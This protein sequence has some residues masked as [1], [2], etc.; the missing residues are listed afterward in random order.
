M[1]KLIICLLVLLMPFNVFAE[2]KLKSETLSEVMEKEG[3]KFEHPNY[4]EDSK[5][6]NIYLFR[7]SGCGYCKKFLTFLESITDEYGNYFNL[8]S[9]EVWNSEENHALMENVK[10]FLNVKKDGVPFIVIGSYKQLG[11]SE[12]DND[13]IKK[14]IVS[15]YNAKKKYDVLKEM[16][17]IHLEK[18][19]IMSLILFCLLV[20]YIVYNEMD[21]RKLKTNIKVKKGK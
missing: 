8:V 5:K 9:Y 10:E 13:N 6:I 14:A 19:D 2:T 15:E 17:K 16:D 7:G 1:K 20:S 12:L 4:H 3:I 11:Y 18:E 21:K